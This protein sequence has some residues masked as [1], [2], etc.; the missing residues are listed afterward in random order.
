LATA[1]VTVLSEVGERW[2]RLTA[3]AFDLVIMLGDN[4]AAGSRPTS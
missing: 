2:R 1:P 4:M 3:F